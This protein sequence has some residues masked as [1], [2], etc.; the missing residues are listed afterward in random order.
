MRRYLRWIIAAVTVA[1][2]AAGALAH[3]MDYRCLMPEEMGS[4]C[5][6]GLALIEAGSGCSEM[7]PGGPDFREAEPPISSAKA[8]LV[9]DYVV[10]DL[11]DLTLEPSA[12][13]SRS[14]GEDPPHARRVTTP[15]RLRVLRI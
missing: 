12:A 3:A 9:P 13:V 15:V 8:P 2:F 11:A 6:D 4:C 1:V 10:A 14:Y 7:A 5:P